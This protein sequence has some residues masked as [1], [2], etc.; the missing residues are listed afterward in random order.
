MET[1]ILLALLTVISLLAAMTTWFFTWKINQQWSDF[2]DRQNNDWSEICTKMTG[3]WI[4][5]YQKIMEVQNNA[6]QEAERNADTAAPS[7]RQA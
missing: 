4:K 2:I 6:T 7:K 1:E 5:L 3:E